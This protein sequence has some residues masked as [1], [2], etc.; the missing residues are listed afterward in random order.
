MKDEHTLYITKLDHI[1]LTRCLYSDSARSSPDRG[2]LELLAEELNKAKIVASGEVT[3]NVI[4]MNSR[5]RL[6]DPDTNKEMLVTL[7]FPEDSDIEQ[8]RLSVLSPVGTAIL[9]YS[10]GDIIELKVP[11]G[12]RRIQILEI[13]Y[14]PEADGNYAL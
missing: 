1:R 7:V 3:P 2:S 8:G 10:L 4:T 9:G 5:V 12:V 11:S 13:C 6:K 14:Q